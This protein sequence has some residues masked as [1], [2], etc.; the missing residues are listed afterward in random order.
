MYLCADEHGNQSSLINMDINSGL[1]VYLLRTLHPL[2]KRIY[3]SH[4]I[5]GYLSSVA[6]TYVNVSKLYLHCEWLI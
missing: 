1:I 6:T 2:T 5:L 4:I 3:E